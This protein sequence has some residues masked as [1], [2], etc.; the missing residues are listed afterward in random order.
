[1][2]KFLKSLF[3]RLFHKIFKTFKKRKDLEYFC[4]LSSKLKSPSLKPTTIHTRHFLHK[5]LFKNFPKIPITQIS[6]IHIYEFINTLISQKL[7]ISTIKQ[8]LSYANDG[9]NLAMEFK[10]VSQNPIKNIKSKLKS[11]PNKLNKIIKLN[12]IKK[13]LNHAKGELKMF[14]YFAFFTGARASEILAITKKDINFKK[15]HILISKNA[16]R[17]GLTSPKNNKSRMIYLP[18][19]LKTEILNSEFSRFSKNYFSIYYQFS[20]LKKSLRLKIGSIHSA[21]HTYAS[22]CLQK[23]IN[24]PLVAELLG[25]NDISMIS[26]VYSHNIYSQKEQTKLRKILHFK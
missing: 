11:T 19:L 14:L 6:K 7:K 21:R 26:K 1:M 15:N 23:N 25:H 13:L 4:T 8:L 2:L 10:T 5:T 22:M 9:F 18:P 20:K 3:T 24:L 17:F 16:T 12:Q